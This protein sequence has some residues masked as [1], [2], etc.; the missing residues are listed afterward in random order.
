MN[1]ILEKVVYTSSIEG[2]FISEKFFINPKTPNDIYVLSEEKILTFQS[3]KP[4][5]LVQTKMN[6]IFWK[7]KTS[8]SKVD[9]KF[10]IVEEQILKDSFLSNKEYTISYLEDFPKL[11]ELVSKSK[12]QIIILFEKFTPTKSQFLIPLKKVKL[13]SNI[14]EIFVENI[15][16]QN[17][18][19]TVVNYHKT[20]WIYLLGNNNPNEIIEY[21]QKLY[22]TNTDILWKEEEEIVSFDYCEF[23]PQTENLLFLGYKNGI[24]HPFSF[25]NLDFRINFYNFVKNDLSKTSS[26]L[27]EI[28]E[29][30]SNIDLKKF[31]R[32]LDEIIKQL[33]TI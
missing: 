33:L 12:D 3:I 13:K 19:A 28:K 29:K 14:N 24:Y 4:E 22:L 17:F 11:E 23:I 6:F 18:S 26:H 7:D 20:M 15:I 9:K 32:N 27:L 16:D 10:Y 21:Y 30:F 25:V 1:K 5:N 8:I 31:F 2:A